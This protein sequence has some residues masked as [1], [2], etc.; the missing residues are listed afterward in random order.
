MSRVNDPV[1]DFSA[2]GTGIRPVIGRRSV[3]RRNTASRE[4]LVQRVAAEFREMPCLRLTPAQARR[5][6]GL[7]DDVSA[8]VIGH[9]VGEGLLRLD[10]DGRYAVVSPS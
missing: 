1:R 9:L 6:F 4:A 2:A 5:L 7:R 3:E 8:R 10:P